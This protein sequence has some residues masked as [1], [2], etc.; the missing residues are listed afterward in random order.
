MT[1]PETM[2]AMLLTGHGGPEKL[3]YRDDVPVPTP[4]VGEV[5]IE[6]TACGMNNTDI[7]VREGSY[8]A[9][10][11]ADAVSTWRSRAG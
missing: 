7:K 5:L 4:G 8:G 6:V 1:L 10:E 3:E 2:N 9:E 11:D